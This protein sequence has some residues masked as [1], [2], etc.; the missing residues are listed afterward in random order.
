MRIVFYTSGLTGAGRLV[1]GISI[2]NA[3]IR[4]GIKCKYTILHSSPV[5]HLADDFHHIKMPIETDTDLSPKNYSKS[6]LYKT[7]KKLKP[8]V[9]LVNHL[10][11]MIHNFI[12]ELKC[13]KIYL[14]DHCYDS[15]F[16]PT[17]DLNFT[18]TQY[19]KVLAIEPFT[20]LIPM[21]RINPLIIRNRDEI[22]AKEAALKRL[23]LT[24]LKK[25]A[26]YSLS[27]NSEDTKSFSDKYSYLEKEYEVLRLSMND[28]YLF[29]IVDFYNAFDMIVCGGGYNNVWAAVY[30]HKRAIFEPEPV[31]Y[32]DQNIR[33]NAS[34]DFNFDVNG[35]DQLVDIM[36]NL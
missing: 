23:G 28:R 17:A 8:D 6:Q 7:L 27:N 24:D 34:K 10:W 33:I 9:L 20:S 32:S 19:D 30:F 4:K 5:A 15:H 2:G 29:P 14:S 26:L 11:Y 16:K 31:N 25:I 3:L 36:M 22:L 21:E 1:M 12:D 13:K 18:N 35:A